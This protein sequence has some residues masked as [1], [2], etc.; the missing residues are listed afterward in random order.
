MLLLS[1][2]HQSHGQES[3]RAFQQRSGARIYHDASGQVIGVEIPGYDPGFERQVVIDDSMQQFFD[4]SRPDPANHEIAL[5]VAFAEAPDRLKGLADLRS[6][7]WI[8]YCGGRFWPPQQDKTRKNEEGRI[9]LVIDAIERLDDIRGVVVF[10]ATIPTG[11]LERIVALE[12]LRAIALIDC[13]LGRR[14]GGNSRIP[15]MKLIR[16]TVD[17]KQQAGKRDRTGI[18]PRLSRSARVTIRDFFSFLDWLSRL[19]LVKRFDLGRAW[20][21]R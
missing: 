13:E 17:E 9:S 10:D 18:W 6:L 11:G 20:L 21:A 19:C 8:V 4:N 5:N 7:K 15:E 16:I 3:A 12:R 2:I 1:N 14:E